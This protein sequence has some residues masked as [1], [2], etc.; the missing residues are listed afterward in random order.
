MTRA[1]RTRTVCKT[2]SDDG[3][4]SELEHI[5]LTASTLFSSVLAHLLHRQG[6][7][8]RG[9]RSGSRSISI[10]LVGF[11]GVAL[12]RWRHVG[13]HSSRDGDGSRRAGVK[14]SFLLCGDVIILFIFTLCTL[15]EP[16]ITHALAIPGY[17]D[18]RREHRHHHANDEGTSQPILLEK[19]LLLLSISASDLST[20]A[21]W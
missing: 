21:W 14:I 6:L 8:R 19:S 11:L 10:G 12:V 16:C 20:F 7:S 1:A 17:F 5:D 15:R 18:Q 3:S 9:L 13:N 2:R 4:P